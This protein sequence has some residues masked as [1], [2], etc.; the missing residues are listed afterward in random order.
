M[1]KSVWIPLICLISFCP[2]LHFSPPLPSSSPSFPFSLPFSLSPPLPLSTPPRSHTQ[3]SGSYYMQFLNMTFTESLYI[4]NHI[5]G[6]DMYVGGVG[7][8]GVSV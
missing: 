4:D 5:Q 3:V 7:V 6:R 1:C 8:Y 2:P